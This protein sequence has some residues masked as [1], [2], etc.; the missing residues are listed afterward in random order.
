VGE[1]TKKNH[2]QKKKKKTLPPSGREEAKE[3][4]DNLIQK[5]PV[6][7]KKWV[8]LKRGDLKGDLSL[9]RA[10]KTSSRCWE[11]VFRSSSLRVQGSPVRRKKERKYVS[12]G[13]LCVIEILPGQ[14]GVEGKI[15]LPQ[16]HA[17][18]LTYLATKKRGRQ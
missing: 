11:P 3:G 18:K 12:G 7:K 2:N 8:G 6:G 4:G 10:W 13:V 15:Q 9:A 1:S 17:N 14:I 5:K 16:D